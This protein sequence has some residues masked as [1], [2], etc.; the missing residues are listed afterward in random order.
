MKLLRTILLVTVWCVISHSVYA[1]S[2][3]ATF[4]FCP[5]EPGLGCGCNAGT[6]VPFADGVDAWC[7]F[8]DRNMNGPDAA[9]SLVPVGADIGQASY[10]C[11]S[12]NGLSVCQIAGNFYSDPSFSMLNM[13]LPPDQP[14]YYL[15]ISGSSCCWVSDTIRLEPGF[16]EYYFTESDFTCTD[17]P[18]PTGTAPDPV[19]NV[20]V[21]DDQFCSRV[22]V[23]WD[24]SGE[25][26]SGFL[27]YVYD[28]E[29]D[30]WE[31][32]YQVAD[33]F[34]SASLDLC[35]DGEV[36]VGVAAANGSQ[37]AEI[38]E[39]VGRTFLRR[40]NPANEFDLDEAAHEIT[41]FLVAP[42]EG[43]I[44]G[45]RLYFDFFS[46]GNFVAHMCQITDPDQLTLMEVTCDLPGQIPNANCYIVMHDSSTADV[47]TGCGLT[48]TIFFAL[49]GDETPE[50]PREFAL[51]QNYPNPFN[52]NTMI[53][54]AVPSEGNVELSVFN[55][56]GQKVATLV[57][58]KVAQGQHIVEWNAQTAATGMYFYR[59]QMGNQVITRKMLLLK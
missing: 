26:L 7:V 53:E 6:R 1:Q 27:I 13:P 52:P 45:A 58:G 29:S 38:V 16:P 12:F 11:Q 10:S 54:F 32:T 21:S 56:V 48:D 5:N 40:F 49:D 43:D 8:W 50:L 33:T 57:N 35:V 46:G 39:G 14:V 15:K 34:R 20:V 28:E 36:R 31:F 37:Q 4:A 30:E 51:K 55:L 2:S 24:H 42:P 9:D 41:M 23:T 25:G 22:R 17:S 44:C 3:V 47:L 59:L 19:T 18:C